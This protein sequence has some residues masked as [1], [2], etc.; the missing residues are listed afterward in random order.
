MSEAPFPP[1]LVSEITIPTTPIVLAALEYSRTHTSVATVNHCLRSTAFALILA[2]KNPAYAS[3]DPETIALCTI[4]HDMG[5]ATTK[6]LLSKDKRF[7]VDGANIARDFIQTEIAHA[8]HDAG[9]AKFDEHRVQLIWDAV[10]LHATPSIAAHKQKEV[11]V[12]ASGILGDF[13]GPHHPS[14][15]ITIDEYKEIVRAFP[16][17]GFREEMPQIMCALCVE[18]PETTYVG[19]MGIKLGAEGH[20]QKWEKNR[21]SDGLHEGLEACKQYEELKLEGSDTIL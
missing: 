4:L 12:T 5:W 20:K 6:S 7:E 14:G 8:D 21:M 17:A 13:V 19:E 10:A 2:R 18:K 11:A 3:V 9:R 16:R 15:M 1:F